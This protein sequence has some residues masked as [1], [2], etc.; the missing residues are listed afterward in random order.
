MR[1]LDLCLI[2]GGKSFVSLHEATFAGNPEEAVRYFSAHR[3]ATAH[4][5]IIR[6]CT[7]D[8]VFVNPQFEPFE[9][10]WIYRAARLRAPRENPLADAERARFQRL[11]TIMIKHAPP[12]G[13]LLDVGC[14]NAMF[15]EIIKEY[16]HIGVEVG[17]PGEEIACGH[18]IILGNLPSLMGWPPFTPGSFDIVTAWDV[19]EHLSDLTGYLKSFA[20]L[21]RPGGH[22]FVTVPNIASFSARLTRGRWNAFLLEHLWYFSPKTLKRLMLN[23]GLECIAQGFVPY[24]VPLAHFANRIAQMYGLRPVVLPQLLRHAVVPLPVGLMFSGFRK[25]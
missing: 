8:F 21:L 3:H 24:D 25:S 23:Y 13:R 19:L 2:C 6:C 11:I 12:P 15:L 20:Q 16:D 10:D 4:G 7:C 1:H 5:R 9:Y 22:L 17:E 14:G 18:Q